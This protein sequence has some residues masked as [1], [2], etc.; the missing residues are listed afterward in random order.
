MLAAL[1]YVWVLCLIPFLFARKNAY[2][3]FHARQGMVLLVLELLLWWF[4][5]LIVL[6]GI[7]SIIGFV[8]AL[9]GT[10]WEIPVVKTILEYI[11]NRKGQ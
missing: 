5:L 6:F 3:Q 8:R 2:V 9:Q 4:P 11:T 10:R 1:S 7:I